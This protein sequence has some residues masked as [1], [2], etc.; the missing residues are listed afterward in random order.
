MALTQAFLIW[1]GAVQSAFGIL[2]RNRGALDYQDL[3]D[4]VERLLLRNES[5][6]RDWVL[7]R[8][9]RQFRHLLVDEAQDN[10]PQQARLVALLAQEFVQ[11][12]NDGDGAPRTVL[13]VGDVKQ[14]IYRFQ[15]ARPEFFL[16]LRDLLG[17]LGHLVEIDMRHSFRTSEAVLAT[18]DAVFSPAELATAVQG[19]HKD[20]PTHAS[21]F[22]GQFGRVEVWPLAV[23]PEPPRPAPWTLPMDRPAQVRGVTVCARAV[24]ERIVGDIAAGTILPSTGRRM[25]AG[26]VLVLT[27]TNANR[28]AVMRELRAAGLPVSGGSLTLEH[29]ALADLFALLRILHNPDDRLAFAT[30]LKGR[31][32]GWSDARL[33]EL[34]RLGPDWWSGLGQLDAPLKTALQSLR[35]AAGSEPPAALLG[36]L[37]HMFKVPARYGRNPVEVADIRAACDNL[38]LL[39]EST[40]T[41]AM[42][43]ARL[44]DGVELAGAQG[45]GVRVMT[46]HKSKGLE[47]PVVVLADTTQPLADT[48]KEKLL[49]LERGNRLGGVI[50]RI[51]ATR[52]TDLQAAADAAEKDR[53]RADSLRLL[54]VAMT[55]ARDVLWIAGWEGRAGPDDC[56][57]GLV[58]AGMERLD[59]ATR[60]DDGRIVFETGTAPAADDS[61]QETAAVAR[62]DVAAGTPLSWPEK[63]AGSAPLPTPAMARGEHLHAWLATAPDPDAPAPAEIVRIR[64]AFPELFA[65]G[66][67]GEVEV[68]LTDGR[69]GR[70]DRLVMRDNEIWIIDFK[71]GRPVSEAIPAAY[72]RQL[73][74]YRSA[75]EP[76]AGGRRLRAGI[77]WTADARLQWLA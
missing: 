22:S 14:S 41:L 12:D 10:S 77:V 18:V 67:H 15:G 2:K 63:D 65:D 35:A 72:A 76:L 64:A 70:I 20:W 59:G 3:L 37:V 1:G 40:P 27:R 7:Y 45:N 29:P 61:P 43:I 34:H 23:P 48:A 60:L 6:F 50:Y 32:A 56:W 71:S 4:A 75:L 46:A 42:A 58:S 52:A 19:E 11:A 74:G 57:Y 68:M 9:D 44:E 38:A 25:G 21:V 69:L 39:L 16:E 62:L 73:E 47:A 8:L 49:W 54:Y 17:R 33:L 26:D 66:S 51:P 53:Q 30:V 5:G 13:A 28:D 36:R 31:L 55:R 24:A